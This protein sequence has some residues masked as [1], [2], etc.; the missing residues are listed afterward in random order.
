MRCF[1][2]AAAFLF[3]P[4]LFAQTTGVLSG[5]VL[6][7]AAAPLPDATVQA[8]LPDTQYTTVSGSDGT[9]RF[10]ALP[11][12]LY[13]IRA[14][15]VGHASAERSEVWVRSGKNE[16][17][18]LNLYY[19]PVELNA[20][21]VETHSIERMK[22]ISS[23][24]LTVEQSL[25]FPATFFDPA[26]LAMSYA[27]VASTSDQ[28]NHFS[29]R[30]NGP[31]ANAWLLEGA[32]IV[33]PNHLTNA[34]TASDLPTLSGGGTTILS[35][36]ML[37]TSHLL[38]GAM[39]SPYGNAVGGI[40]DLRLRP[41]STERQAFTLQAGLIGLDLC[42]EGPLRK[43]GRASYLINYRYSTLGLLGG[44]GVAL[45]DEAISF[46]DLSF[47]FALPVGTNELTVFGMGGNSSNRFA[48]KD[49]TEWEFDKDSQNI[50]YTAMV[51]AAGVSF[52]K[53]LGKNGSWK[54]T[55]VISANDQERFSERTDDVS[56]AA[57]WMFRDT[58]S[59][60]EQ[61]L[62]VVSMVNMHVGKRT[63][64]VVGGSAMQRTVGKANRL[65]NESL[66]GWL[67]RPF[68]RLERNV[69]AQVQVDLGLAYAL[70]TANASACV[71]PR[72]TMH[73]NANER[74]KI[75]LGA[76][77][78]SQVP[79]VQ[80]YALHYRWIAQQPIAPTDNSAIGLLRSQDVELTY[81]HRFTRFFRSTLTGFVQR[82]LDV[83]VGGQLEMAISGG[84]YSLLNEWDALTVLPLTAQGEG[85]NAGGQFSLER[86]MH[87]NLFYQVNA[88]VFNSTYS[89]RSG[90]T[91]NTRWNTGVIANAVLGREFVKQ[92]AD[93]KR[94][95]GVNGRLNYTGGQWYTPRAVQIGEVVATYSAQLKA[96]YRVDL[97]IYLKRERQGRTGIWSLDLL[98]A[99]N[100]QNE[101]YRYFDFRKGE[102]VT[103]YQLGLIPNISYRVEF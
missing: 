20:V 38:M 80:N 92:K 95:W 87:R 57:S 27:G 41:G 21:E 73:W 8:V 50:D 18:E 58:A 67:L 88:T 42:A 99:T 85:F 23:I 49:S 83:P 53:G 19:A 32:E 25:R 98:N 12:G 9:F 56:G 39:A 66:T 70:W 86:T 55:A 15:H 103:K 59:L 7:G 97:R 30:G 51:G 5:R 102:E 71:E 13:L 82:L 17:V 10:A 91:V 31:M 101:A 28:A 77:Q 40:M 48:A 34:G 6:N 16:R 4:L 11:T 65:V 46:Q 79:S 89:D 43:G 69:G 63:R 22:S 33:T 62:S 45:G 52:A 96:A 64:V 75:S 60:L 14:S 29:I 94:T 2:A 1:S 78:R 26:R 44:M 36:Q 3:A 74:N 47:H 37:G 76:G 61:K 81:E 84:G 93:R 54:T 24:P 72:V 90:E 68:A 100:A 35:A